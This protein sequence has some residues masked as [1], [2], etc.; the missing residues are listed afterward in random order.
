MLQSQL[1]DSGNK[2]ATKS[3]RFLSYL[4]Y[5]EEKTAD[6]VEQCRELIKEEIDFFFGL[7]YKSIPLVSQKALKS[8]SP[9]VKKDFYQY[10][11]VPDQLTELMERLGKKIKKEINLYFQKE[12]VL[13][14]QEKNWANLDQALINLEEKTKL[15]TRHLF[16][17]GYLE[18]NLDSYCGKLLDCLIPKN[19]PGKLLAKPKWG[20]KVL[21]LGEVSKREIEK[22]YLNEMNNKLKGILDNLKLE[23]IASIQKEVTEKV[24]QLQDENIEYLTVLD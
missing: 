23:L 20:Q 9:E 15:Y 17:A 14:Y 1:I 19:W 12:I 13:V 7:H 16:I 18:K 8:Q 22:R 4:P 11:L 24:Y 5:Y 6:L 21:G 2:V 10:L 3:K